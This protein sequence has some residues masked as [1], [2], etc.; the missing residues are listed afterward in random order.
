MWLHFT[1]DYHLEGNKQTKCTNQTLKQYLYIYYNYQQDN[2]SKLL[3]LIEFAYNNTP[4]A[5]TGV[6]P[7]FANKRYHLNITIHPKCDIAST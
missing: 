1:S 3:S 5:T 4:S 2:W 6:F 7:F